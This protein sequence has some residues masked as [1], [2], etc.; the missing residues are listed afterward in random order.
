[1]KVLIMSLAV[2]AGLALTSCRTTYTSTSDNA[3]YN[4][5]VPVGIR[6]NFA[7]QYPD[8]TNV[9]WN[10]YDAAAVPIDWELTDWTPLDP[11]DYA[12]SF[13]M[14]NNK[15]YAWY[16]SN[17]NTLVGSAFAVS[18]Y[19]RLPY[20]VSNLIANNYQGYTIESAQRESWKTKT[21]YELK[22][23]N[24]TSKVKLLVDSDGNILKE[25]R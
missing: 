22:L 1:M 7:V 19:S 10:M 24:G 21:G 4:V 15:Y 3:A 2:A 11:Q 18:D 14:G 6:S 8:A 13:N 17:G 20:A 9:V 5:D 25:K 23:T 12:V 16:D